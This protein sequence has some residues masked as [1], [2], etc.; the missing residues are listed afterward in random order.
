M[1]FNRDL[2]FIG[3]QVSMSF[4]KDTAI[5]NVERLGAR[6]R[7]K[8]KEKKLSQAALAE[9]LGVERKWVLKLEAGNPK[10]ELGL[11]LQALQYL[12]FRLALDQLS[13]SSPTKLAERP[14]TPI[15]EVFS[16]LNR[17]RRK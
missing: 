8:R 16:R 13:A 1:S 15:S 12:G 11:V 4:M 14:T 7:L 6:I 3:D 2:S 17:Q 10:A 9:R 5:A